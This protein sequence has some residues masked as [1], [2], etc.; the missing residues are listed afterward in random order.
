MRQFL[1]LALVTATFGAPAYAQA[2]M[3]QMNHMD[4]MD[5]QAHMAAMQEDARQ[6][7]DFPPAMRRHNLANM[8]DHLSALTE[9]LDA[10][11]GARYAQAGQI[12]SARLGMGSPSA[13]G[14]KGGTA[15]PAMSMPGSMEQ[16]MSGF[17]PEGMRTLGLGMHQAANDF[18]AAAAKAAK[19][20]NARP[21]LAALTR[22]TQQCVACH[23]TYRVQ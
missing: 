19:T 5:H 23:S 16:Q 12:A 7:V 8:R 10:L 15:A 3:S 14:C 9:I 4:H 17:M 21:A 13:E 11:A 20:H 6:L 18:A 22:V 1:I 2:P